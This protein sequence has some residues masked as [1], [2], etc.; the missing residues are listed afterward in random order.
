MDWVA[1]CHT[2]HVCVGGVEFHWLDS[3]ADSLQPLVQLRLERVNQMF[4]TALTNASIEDGQTT[5]LDLNPVERQP[6]PT[7]RWKVSYVLSN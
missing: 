2:P 6:A 3:T 1:T 4:E 7:A 5:R